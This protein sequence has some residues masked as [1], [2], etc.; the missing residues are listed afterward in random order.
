[1]APPAPPPGGLED[2]S[3]WRPIRDRQMPPLHVPTLDRVAETAHRQAVEFLILDQADQCGRT[4]VLNHIE[5]Q[6]EIPRPGTEPRGAIRLAGAQRDADPALGAV[7]G[8]H[9]DA[10]RITH[11]G[12]GGRHVRLM[13]RHDCPTVPNARQVWISTAADAE[14]HDPQSSRRRSGAPGAARW[15][16]SSSGMASRH[17]RE[18]CAVWTRCRLARMVGAWRQTRTV[19]CMVRVIHGLSS[20]HRVAHASMSRRI[21]SGS[22]RSVIVCRSPI[23]S[24]TFVRTRRRTW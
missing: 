3:R 21:W 20:C 15:G 16:Q 19:R 7:G 12:L 17:V 24:G 8:Y 5:V 13:R 22:L 9:G 1:M 2:G 11:A 10:K 6:I 23:I 4:P 14:R 18:M